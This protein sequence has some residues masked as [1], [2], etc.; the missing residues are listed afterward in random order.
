MTGFSERKPR[1]KFLSR[2]IA[3]ARMALI[4][5]DLVLRLWR[6]ASLFILFLGLAFLGLWTWLPGILHVLSLAF[7]V[8]VTP[9][10][11]W[12]DFR[13]LSQPREEEV[14]RRLERKSGLDHRPLV[15]LEDAYAGDR[16]DEASLALFEMHRQRMA[17]RIRRMKVG[18]PLSDVVSHDRFGLR[19]LALLVLAWG[20]VA[21]WPEA[22]ANF[23]AL[24]QPGFST[25]GDAGGT[26]ELT[27]WIT[28]PSYT[29]VAPIWFDHGSEDREET[30]GPIPV[31]A[32]SD[33]VVQVRGGSDAPVLTVDDVATLFDSAGA[34]S[35]EISR[36]LDSGTRF[37]ISQSDVV[38]AERAIDIIADR[39]PEIILTS[40]PSETLRTGLRLDVAAR[41]DYGLEN[42]RGEMRRVGGDPE[43]VFLVSVP[44]AQTGIRTMSG[45]VFYNL[46]AH[47]W[48]GLDVELVLVAT[49]VVGQETVSGSHAF[50]LP[51]R[52]FYH[53]VARE[54]A[55]QRKA[56]V[57]DRN[58]A[59][60]TAS[61]LAGLSK[62]PEAYLGEFG[63]HLALVT[64]AL[65]LDYSADADSTPDAVIGLMWETALA[66]EEGPLAFAEQRVRELQE[67]ILEALAEG[68]SDAEIERLL[69]ELRNAMDE[70]MRALSNRL[71]S[72]PGDLFDP[73]EALK[74]V[75]SR[76]LTDLVDRITELVRTGSRLQAQSL[77][78]RLQEIMENISM[79]NLS[80]LSGSS[81]AEAVEMIQTIRRL[82]TDQQV[83][84]DE[85]YRILRENEDG[86][87]DTSPQAERQGEVQSIL[88]GFMERME[89]FGYDAPRQYTRAN[90][91]MGRAVRQLEADRPG[92]AVDH[93]TEAI[94]FLRGGADDMMSQ[95]LELLGQSASGNAQGFFSAPRDPIGRSLGDAIGSD[96]SDIN[97]PDKGAIIRA[98][99]ILDELNRRAA[100]QHRP[101]EEQNYLQRLLRRF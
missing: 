60:E 91:S 97:I 63:V 41:D 53:P 78:T 40:E 81:S 6:G 58:L 76:E 12:R 3:L 66:V 27:L 52:Y 101:Q 31:P 22:R 35:W 74:A 34:G 84:L 43:D 5:E 25:L 57:G 45:P 62:D 89:Q 100:E 55:K 46:M 69:M 90:R 24:V 28:P 42:I 73:T 38:M 95:I 83:L 67:R 39:P 16:Q 4:W 19:F 94:D 72:D 98:R 99:Q 85:S 8:V 71:R 9:L 11:L 56:L 37:S 23:T 13:G 20:A 44:L 65:R 75:G 68:A 80:D 70:Y 88:Q 30:A 33:L 15:A 87:I 17:E 79:G 26:G 21:G 32:G 2:R 86:K 1:S 92:H 54:L 51:E 59:D 49:D 64:A 14:L 18:W 50:A 10:V 77:L 93:Q 7:F 96:N 36:V 29:G 48:A 82:I 47:P 61:V